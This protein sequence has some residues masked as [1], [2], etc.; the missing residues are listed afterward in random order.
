MDSTT[1][2]GHETF[3][4]VLRCFSRPGT[5]GRLPSGCGG[6]VEA[7]ERFA[8]CVVDPECTIGAIGESMDERASRL[9]RLTGSPRVDPELADFVLV[10]AG[11]TGMLHSLRVGTPDYPDR[12][13]TLL[14]V[15]RNL[16]ESGGDWLWRGPGISGAVSPRIEGL[17]DGELDEIA[18]VNASYPLGLDALFVDETG[19]FVALPRSTR[20]DR[21]V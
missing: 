11:G 15:V 1:I 7:L 6:A 18:M 3:R 13:A 20:L 19:A 5:V 17:A 16:S 9:S 14:Y 12:G 21:R 4:M 10:G 2:R 8:E